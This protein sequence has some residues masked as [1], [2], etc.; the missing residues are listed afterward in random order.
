VSINDDVLDIPA[1][2]VRSRRVLDETEQRGYGH[3]ENVTDVVVSS[4]GRWWE[5]V[6]HVS[7]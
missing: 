1:F 7:P 6:Q 3:V 4:D 5:G 2:I